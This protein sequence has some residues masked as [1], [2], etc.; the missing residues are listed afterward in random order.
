MPINDWDGTAESE[1]KI[2]QDWDGTTA[3]KLQKV[4]DWDGTVEHLIYTAETQALTEF[5]WGSHY[6]ENGAYGDLTVSNGQIAASVG[7]YVN[8]SV[9]TTHTVDFSQY[10]KMTVVYEVTKS[11]T[12]YEWNRHFGVV[13]HSSVSYTYEGDRSDTSDTDFG[14]E[15]L[16]AAGHDNLA[17]GSYT[18]TFDISSWT[19]S[20]YLGVIVGCGKDDT[21]EMTISSIIFE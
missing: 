14:T 21:L 17:V 1:N 2:H 11:T 15:H 20:K 12:S 10:S 3:Y 7:A 13:A 16:A 6:N 9:W 5:T 4:T 8:K 18:L 19:G